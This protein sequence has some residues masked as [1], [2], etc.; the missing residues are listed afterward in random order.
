MGPPSPAPTSL[1]PLVP[2]VRG[3][4]RGDHVHA[5]RTGHGGAHRP[6]R[7]GSARRAGPDPPGADDRRLDSAD[8]ELPPPTTGGS[9]MT[10]EPISSGT[11][12]AD[13]PWQLKTPP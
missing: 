12:S 6:N 2:Q 4:R 1:A 3:H 11:G 9:S 5:F 8:R 13:D 10:D 7:V